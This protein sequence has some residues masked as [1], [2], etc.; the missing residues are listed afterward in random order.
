[1]SNEAQP[2]LL[3]L[4]SLLLVASVVVSAAGV[5]QALNVGVTGFCV[6]ATVDDDDEPLSGQGELVSIFSSTFSSSS[7]SSLSSSLIL[8]L[9]SE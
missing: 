1:V 3:L 9:I 4:V 8:F 5:T 2:A 7:S 6:W